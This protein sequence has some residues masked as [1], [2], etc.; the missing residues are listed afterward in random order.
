MNAMQQLLL[1]GGAMDLQR[2]IHFVCQRGLALIA[3]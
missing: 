3:A 2:F 1:K